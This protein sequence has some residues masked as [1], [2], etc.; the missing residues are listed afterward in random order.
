MDLTRIAIRAVVA[1]VYLLTVT[2]LSGKQLIAQATPFDFVA[3]LILG[4]LVD[5][6]LWADVPISQFATAVATILATDAFVKIASWHSPRF[7]RLVHGLPTVVMRH[8]V[9]NRDE[10]RKEQLNE[11]DLEHLMRL[12]HLDRENWKGVR[13]GV[14]EIDDELSILEEEW[15]KAATREDLPAVKEMLR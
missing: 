14:L 2:R 5:D 8:G 11:L 15:A 3:S 7:F 6:G 1:Y 10:L 9:E 13:L 4:D 12:D